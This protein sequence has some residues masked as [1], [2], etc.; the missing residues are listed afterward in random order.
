MLLACQCSDSLSCTCRINLLDHSV[1]A[2]PIFAHNQHPHINYLARS[3]PQSSS[4]D[5]QSPVYTPSAHAQSRTYPHDLE[6]RLQPPPIPQL[7]APVSHHFS[8][9]LYSTNHVPSMPANHAYHHALAPLLPLQNT[10][11][12]NS[13]KRVASITPLPGQPASKQPHRGPALLNPPTTSTASLPPRAAQ[14]LPPPPPPPPPPEVLAIY[15][16]G[17]TTAPPNPSGSILSACA[18]VDPLTAEQQAWIQDDPITRRQNA[19]S[20]SDV[21]YFCQPVTN[22]SPPDHGELPEL[23]KVMYAKPRDGYVLCKFCL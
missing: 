14:L 5:N 10:T 4:P 19:S 9:S 1:P 12:L 15:G 21:W 18:R 16:V 22:A 23:G 20:A 13:R 8:N 17:P 3:N 7:L 2:T 11:N 6:P